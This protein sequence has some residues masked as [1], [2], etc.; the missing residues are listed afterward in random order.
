M[1]KNPYFENPNILKGE[2][3]DIVNAANDKLFQ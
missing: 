3:A 2:N 1:R